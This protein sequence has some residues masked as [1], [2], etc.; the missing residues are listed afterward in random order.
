MPPVAWYVV[1]D[2]A[3]N[4]IKEKSANWLF[5][6]QFWRWCQNIASWRFN[7]KIWCWWWIAKPIKQ[8]FGNFFWHI[9]LQKSTIFL[10]V[11]QGSFSFLEIFYKETG[12]MWQDHQFNYWRW[13]FRFE[14]PDQQ[15]A[16]LAQWKFLF[17]ILILQKKC[18]N[19]GI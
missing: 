13:V 18:C 1:L 5:F 9:S 6:A 2:L 14:M 8:H 4:C 11:Y 15:F 16:C 7:Q 10:F 3:F 12:V 17:L 19:N